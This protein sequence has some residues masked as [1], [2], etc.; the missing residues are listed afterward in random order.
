MTAEASAIYNVLGD[1]VQGNPES[2]WTFA[3]PPALMNEQIAIAVTLVWL[4]SDSAHS[5]FSR[6]LLH[7]DC[8]AAGWSAQGSWSPVNAFSRQVRD[9]E[10]FL[11]RIL[12]IPMSFVHTKAHVGHPYNEMA[13]VCANVAAQAAHPFVRPPPEICRIVQESDL[14]WLAMAFD[15][16]AL[17]IQAGR[18]LSWTTTGPQ[19]TSHLQPEQLVP[20]KTTGASK[21]QQQ[22]DF[23]AITLN[24]QSLNGKCRYYEDQLDELGVNLA[25][26]QETMGHTGLCSSKRFLR[27]STESAKHWGVAIWMSRTRGLMQC[28]GSP[29]IAQ[30]EDI[31]V[32]HESPRL[33]MIAINMAQ[34][35]IIVGSGHCPH[36]ARQDEARIFHEDLAQCLGRYREAGV[37]IL[38]LDLNG[39]VPTGVN[40]VTGGLEHGEPDYNGRAM[41]ETAMEASLWFPATFHEYHSGTTTTY[42]QANGAEH[43]IDYVAVGGR[44][45]TSEIASWVETAI[46]TA[47]ANDDHDAVVLEVTGHIGSA[48]VQK[49]LHRPRYDTAKMVTMDGRHIIEK[50]LA[51]YRPPDWAMHP[52]D[53]CQHL[54]DF[55]HGVMQKHFSLD[56]ARPRA[57]YI[58]SEVWRLRQGK[59]GL[60]R[61]TRHRKYLGEALLT[62]AFLQ[63]KTSEDYGIMVLLRKQLLLYEITAGAIRWAT[64]AIKRGI[65][66]AKTAFLQSLA[67]E[68]GDKGCDVLRKAKAA[69]IG[70]R[71]ARPISRPLP[72]LK[73]ASGAPTQ[74][75]EDRDKVWMEHFGA[76]EMGQTVKT[77]DFLQDDGQE[78]Y[79]DVEI[80]WT[81]RD[82]PTI[83]EVEESLRMVPKH[84]APGLDGVP[85]EILSAAPQEM[86]RALYP[87]VA[88]SVLQLHQP[89]QWRGGILRES[90]KRQGS[91]DN[92]ASYRS[93]FISSQVGKCFHKLLR[94]RAGP[95]I[96]TALHEFHL[97]ARRNA[98]VVYPALYVHGFLRRAK[99]LGHSASVLFLDTQSAYYRVIRELAVGH[100][101]S[102]MAVAHVFK[103]FIGPEEMHEFAALMRQGGMLDDA[104]FSAPARHLAKD[105]L[106]RSWF[107]TRHGNGDHITSTHAGSR[108]GES[109]ADVIFSFVLSKIL[110]QIME[111]ATAENLLTDITYIHEGGIYGQDGPRQTLQAKDGT[112]ADDS[113]LPLSD[114]DPQRLL[115]KTSRMGSIILDYCQRHGMAPNLRPKKTAIILAVRGKGSQRARRLWFQ[116]G[117]KDIHLRDLELR[118]NVASQYVHLGGL[119]DPE[120]RLLGEARRRICMAKSA[121]DAGKALLYTNMA[122]PLKVRAALFATSVTSTFFNLAL[123][124]EV[125]EAW[126]KLEHGFS[127]ILKGLLSKTYKGDLLYK[128]LA[129]IVHVLTG[130]PPLTSLARKA[131]I[132][133]LC[134]MAKS[135]PTS[136]WA[137]LQEERT[138]LNQICLDLQWLVAGDRRWPTVGGDNWLEWRHLLRSSAPWVKRRVKAKIHEDMKQFRRHTITMTWL[139]AIWRRAAT[140]AMEDRATTWTCRPCGKRLRTRAA[141]GAHFFKSH[142]RLAK[143]RIFVQGTLCKACGREFWSRSKLSIHLR[144]AP[145]CVR[146]LH[147]ARMFATE[148]A[149]GLGSKRW[150]QRTDEDYTLATSQSMVMPMPDVDS[151]T[152]HEPLWKAHRDLSDLLTSGDLPELEAAA[153]ELIQA[154]MAN[155]PLYPEEMDELAAFLLQEAIELHRAD[156]VEGWTEGVFEA[157]TGVLRRFNGAIWNSDGGTFED[158]SMTTLRDFQNGADTIDW[159]SLCQKPDDLDETPKATLRLTEDWEAAMTSDS[160]VADVAA[161]QSTYWL[162]VPEALRVTW[163]ATRTGVAVQLW[164]PESFWKSP[165]ARPFEHVRASVAS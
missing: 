12:T 92:P 45:Q 56:D 152:W 72:S 134:S 100:V 108:P 130:V 29:L 90:W 139:W 40:G 96:E 80:N 8:Y 141:L 101:A 11:R 2:P 118:I 82:I 6:I 117:A 62:R 99:Q 52:D 151:E 93:L 43:R 161:V 156:A 94:R 121:F 61:R 114:Q 27:L 135:A 68:E 37:I 106:H 102:D 89:V 28:N 150:R 47:N 35:K 142:Q 164:A 16:D 42:R 120:M 3:A 125:G 128:V 5:C 85:G 70:G 23:K 36:S 155:H 162:A 9:L 7:F 163:D 66:R 25:F 147:E 111:Q 73:M 51:Q 95:I 87:L 112:W 136:L 57:S 143:H 154:R 98:P 60:K 64:D 59:L 116:N 77:M 123:W 110:L 22:T 86:S 76:Q 78:I 67:Y 165:L 109:W 10:R 48:S 132:S 104:G 31:H 157:L 13:D 126:Q 55:L 44:M 144:D 69:G 79:Q 146:N 83:Q 145:L 4:L 107:V 140:P 129:P 65:G 138:W 97:G 105:L 124:V 54:Q 119:V 160:S 158:E 38:G 14:S 63:W 17:P 58:P 15:Y 26:F 30:A 39:R 103:F 91:I 50:E 21:G 127:K 34:C 53:H 20:T 159:A 71:H 46:D 137:V 81:M 19:G 41:T 122:I 75:W 113:A 148:L 1:Q 18:C 49:R 133:L 84:K 33:L 88:K 74:S 115:A 24:A 131:R 32:V 153:L 149:P